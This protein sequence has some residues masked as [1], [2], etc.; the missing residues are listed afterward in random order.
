MSP[1]KEDFYDPYRNGGVVNSTPL[2]ESPIISVGDVMSGRQQLPP[3]RISVGYE[4]MPIQ[5]MYPNSGIYPQPMPPQYQQYQIGYPMYRPI[6]YSRADI[7]ERRLVDEASRKY[8]SVL[9]N[10]EYIKF[11]KDTDDERSEAKKYIE[12]I[13]VKNRERELIKEKVAIGKQKILALMGEEQPLDPSMYY[14]NPALYSLRMA[15][16]ENQQRKIIKEQENT[17]K[18]FQDLYR[19]FHSDMDKDKLESIVEQI[20]PEN[21]RRIIAEAEKERIRKCNEFPDICVTIIRGDKTYKYKGTNNPYKGN[22]EF[23]SLN[24]FEE[25]NRI[26]KEEGVHIIDCSHINSPQEMNHAA[27]INQAS[28]PYEF[29]VTLNPIVAQRMHSMYDKYQNMSTYEFLGNAGTLYAQALQDDVYKRD[30]AI[31]MKH[32]YDYSEFRNMFDKNILSAGA[33]LNYF[34]RNE[35]QQYM[36]K[37][38]LEIKLPNELQRNEVYMERRRQF[39]DKI[40]QNAKR[41]GTDITLGGNINPMEVYNSD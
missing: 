39:I 25:Q 11:L 40:M 36:N 22:G 20:D 29:K 28:Y 2:N 38:D 15:N 14:Q 34:N 7:E 8:A 4:R 27:M 6:Y 18:L 41:V 24:Q 37:N 35:A 3:P 9:N 19:K 32:K 13:R 10:P 21:K 12:S 5:Q 26:A 33:S 1:I 17:I 16:Y 31:A 30:M 23:F